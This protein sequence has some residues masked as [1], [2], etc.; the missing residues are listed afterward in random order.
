MTL[1]VRALVTTALM[2]LFLVSGVLPAN[3]APSERDVVIKTIPTVPDFPIT[4]DDETVLTDESGI[5]QFQTRDKESLTQRV[6][7]KNQKLKLEGRKVRVQPSN[8]YLEAAEPAVAMDVFWR[9]G[10]SFVDLHGAPVDVGRIE[11]VQLKSSTGELLEVPANE[12]LWLQGSRVVSL[13]GGPEYKKI[14]WSIEAVQYASSNV[15]NSAQQRFEPA[16]TGEVEVVLL[17]Y[18]TKVTVKDAF[19]G[20]GVGNAVLVTSPD[21]HVDRFPLDDN[22]TVELPSL[23]RGNYSITVEGPGP[24]MDRPVAISRDQ[25]LD[26]KFYSWLDIGLVG[27]FL[28]AFA[29]GTLCVGWW[30]R[31]VHRRVSEDDSEGQYQLDYES[32]STIQLPTTPAPTATASLA[33]P[34]WESVATARP[35]AVRHSHRHERAPESR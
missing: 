29:I 25:V 32:A 15:V 22:S 28:A 5:A 1:A 21:G 35:P 19:F 27:G 26:L 23:P 6:K 10:F 17:F 33:L 4:L 34:P 16:D 13:N 2:A 11:Y 14:Q 9:V 20:F 12:S 24:R 8:K 30:R 31:R 3:A 7:V 18:R